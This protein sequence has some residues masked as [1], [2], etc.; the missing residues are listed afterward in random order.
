MHGECPDGDNMLIKLKVD[1]ELI[2]TC[3]TDFADGDIVKLEDNH[4]DTFENVDEEL[5]FTWQSP[6]KSFITT[7]RT[8]IGA[9]SSP[10]FQMHTML[11]GVSN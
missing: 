9:M 3:L 1:N 11:T 7:E 6:L 2:F 10:Y 5:S 8:E 4:F